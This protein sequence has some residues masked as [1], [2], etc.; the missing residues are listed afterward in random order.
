MDKFTPRTDISTE[1]ISTKPF[2]GWYMQ[3]VKGMVLVNPWFCVP[4]KIGKRLRAA[5]KFLNWI[6][7]DCKPIVKKAEYLGFKIVGYNTFRR[8]RNLAWRAA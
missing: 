3:E 2:K 8:F 4:T 6:F 5:N 1:V 7:L